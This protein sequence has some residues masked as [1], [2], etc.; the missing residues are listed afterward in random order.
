MAYAI[1]LNHYA[2]REIGLFARLR[3]AFDDHRAYLSVRRELDALTDRELS[4]L[5]ISRHNI[6]DIAREAAYGA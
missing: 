4:D 5:G 2:A 1:S 6:G 3:K